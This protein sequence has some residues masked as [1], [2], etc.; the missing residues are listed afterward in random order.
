MKKAI[1]IH[2]KCKCSFETR[3]KLIEY[4][5]QFFIHR[6]LENE[7]EP[8]DKSYLSKKIIHLG[9]SAEL[10]C[11]Y[12]ENNLSDSRTEELHRLLEQI[13]KDKGFL[14]S[15]VHTTNGL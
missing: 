13:H 15:T 4:G 2:L 14:E 8:I 9:S 5:F 11:I 6:K 1:T 7:Y 12:N 10:I 3:K